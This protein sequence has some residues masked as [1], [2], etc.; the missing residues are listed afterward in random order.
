MKALSLIALLLATGGTMAHA[1]NG[2]GHR[3]DPEFLNSL[4]Q[5]KLHMGVSGPHIV[6]DVR[7][8]DA[9]VSKGWHYMDALY[10]GWQYNNGTPF[11]YAWDGYTVLYDLSDDHMLATALAIPCVNGYQLGYHVVGAPNNFIYDKTES[12]TYP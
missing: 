4:L 1:S 5:Q 11:F 10:C 6:I 7:H 2:L 3:A 12:F 8:P 9:P